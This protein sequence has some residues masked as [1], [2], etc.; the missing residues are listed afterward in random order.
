MAPGQRVRALF[1]ILSGSVEVEGPGNGGKEQDQSLAGS[2]QPP[3]PQASPVHTPADYSMGIPTNVHGVDQDSG[4]TWQV[5]P[6]CSVGGWC[7]ARGEAAM[8][9]VRIPPSA[10]ASTVA[11]ALSVDK[12]HTCMW[13]WA[14]SELRSSV[15]TAATFQHLPPAV[16]SAAER[17]V[18]LMHVPAGTPLCVEERRPDACVVLIQGLATS[19]R[20]HDTM[21][22]FSH[23]Q[24][25]TTGRSDRGQSP[26]RPAV[27]L[28]GATPG[29][30]EAPKRRSVLVVGKSAKPENV[31]P[32]RGED[33]EPP[34]FSHIHDEEREGGEALHK[35]KASTER[36]KIIC[37][38][39]SRLAAASNKNSRLARESDVDHVF[40]QPEPAGRSGG[41]KPGCFRAAVRADVAATAQGS[42]GVA[43]PQV[44]QIAASPLASTPASSCATPGFVCPQA[45]QPPSKRGG[46]PAVGSGLCSVLEAHNHVLSEAVL[47]PGAHNSV[48]NF[49]Y[50]S[51]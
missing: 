2:L 25:P 13:Q 45:L 30:K 19:C 26:P 44:P 6:G 9:T 23:D 20:M 29:D 34:P 10:A 18:H 42:A 5:G 22:T 24:N 7:A 15:F 46:S 36:W 3:A 14:L 4:S 37:D 32:T 35:T 1:V 31:S 41:W 12:L 49:P 40:E 11:L 51:L 39:L 43:K 27:P 17:H 8:H 16:R 48:F 50:K 28:V 33:V 47:Q 38:E 21:A